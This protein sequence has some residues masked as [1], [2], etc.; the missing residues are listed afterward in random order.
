MEF[1]KV[2]GLGRKKN[3]EIIAENFPNLQKEIGFYMSMK[4]TQ[5]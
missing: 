3:E 2:N 4:F 1:Q 5:F